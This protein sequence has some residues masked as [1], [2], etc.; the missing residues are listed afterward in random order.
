MLLILLRWWLYGY[1]YLT[2]VGPPAVDPALAQ[3]SQ[4]H[5][6][7]FVEDSTAFLLVVLQ[8]LESGQADP[9]ALVADA[10]YAIDLLA[11][12]EQGLLA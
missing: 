4:K 7:D 6:P 9:A 8:A 5:P 1:K 3:I 11:V 12:A 2:V 10:E